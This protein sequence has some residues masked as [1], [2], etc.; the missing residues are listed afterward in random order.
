MVSGYAGQRSG[1][2]LGASLQELSDGGSLR[3]MLARV[4][5]TY[6]REA[7]TIRSAAIL[8]DKDPAARKKIEDFA[9]EFYESG[10]KADLARIESFAKARGIVAAPMT[11]DEARA[12]KLIPVRVKPNAPLTMGGGGGRNVSPQDVERLTGMGL[13]EA[14]AFANGKRSVLDIRDAVSAEFGGI[15]VKLFLAVFDD[16]AKS[17]DFELVQK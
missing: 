10:M 11:S 9:N 15:D 1:K 13:S 7:D 2:E 4:K 16:L 6:E 12:S 14:K 5:V 3:A 8:A 17:G